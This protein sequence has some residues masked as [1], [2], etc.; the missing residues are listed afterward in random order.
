[1]EFLGHTFKFEQGNQMVRCGSHKT[2]IE[3][4]TPSLATI[5][6]VI[7][8]ESPSPSKN[9]T[10]KEMERSTR[11]REGKDKKEKKASTNFMG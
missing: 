9:Y 2:V 11:K 4:S 3:G 1:M 7:C 8:E 6:G 10:R 5:I